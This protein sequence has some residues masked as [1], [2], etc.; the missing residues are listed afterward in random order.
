M[1]RV[2]VPPAAFGVKGNVL[3]NEATPVMAR[4]E[5]MV[6]GG[7]TSAAGDERMASSTWHLW[8]EIRKHY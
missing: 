4:H 2:N 7:K 6:L 3:S 1:R 8:Q 5:L